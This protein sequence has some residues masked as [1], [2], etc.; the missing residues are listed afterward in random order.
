ML[1]PASNSL[2]SCLGLD[3]VAGS[4]FVGTGCQ[5]ACLQDGDVREA[6]AESRRVLRLSAMSWRAAPTEPVMIG[7]PLRWKV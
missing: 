1:L 6:A 5:C 7:M 4:A 3:V 2:S